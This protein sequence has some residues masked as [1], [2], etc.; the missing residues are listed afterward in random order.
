MTHVKYP[1]LTFIVCLPVI[2]LNGV[3]K[4]Q[5]IEVYTRNK[6]PCSARITGQVSVHRFFRV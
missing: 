3:F 1:S 2:I 5:R 4:F 6:G